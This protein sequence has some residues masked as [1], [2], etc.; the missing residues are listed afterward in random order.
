MKT[1]LI[2]LL[3]VSSIFNVW[4][5]D[6]APEKLLMFRDKI[7][8]AIIK[9]KQT[10]RKHWAYIVTRHENEEGDISSSI[11][12]HSP[13]LSEPW[14]L[15]QIN[16]KQPTGKQIQ[17]FSD[18]KRQQTKTKKQKNSLKLSLRELINEESLTFVSEDDEQFVMAFNVRL[19]KLGEDSIGKLKGQ[20]TYQKEAQ[21]ID[22]ISIW[23]SADFSPMFTAHITDFVMT[24]S[25]IQ[26]DGK[27]LPKQHEMAMKG[28]FAYFTE[29]N[30]TS[31]DIYSDYKYIGK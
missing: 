5:T 19:K 4:A 21:F 7:N 13:Q 22:T 28:S 25:F 16:G 11:E 8:L 20:L 14:L 30:E 6:V 29:I 2:F 31:I 24:M 18:K 15:K 26:L 27:V 10:E 23:N 9:A 1:Y 17:N 3:G 12:Q